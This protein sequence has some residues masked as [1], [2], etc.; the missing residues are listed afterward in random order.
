MK[1]LRFFA[2]ALAFASL[3]ATAGRASVPVINYENVS[4][5]NAA[6]QPATAEEIRR[7]FEFAAALRGWQIAHSRPGQMVATYTKQGKHTVSTDISYSPGKYS[8]KYRDSVNMRYEP[9]G[10]GQGLIHPHYN[11]WVEFL[12]NDAR[13]A[14]L[15]P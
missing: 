9:A 6:G 14:L 2:I 8:I 5:T 12:S 3:S 13:A 15:R 1:I 4:I 11:K 7:A 10:E